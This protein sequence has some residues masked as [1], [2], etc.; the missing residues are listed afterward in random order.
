MSS[1]AF[2]PS[3]EDS[4]TGMPLF[5][6]SLKTLR[7][8]NGLKIILY[9]LRAKGSFFRR[10]AAVP[11]NPGRTSQRTRR[12][13]SLTAQSAKAETAHSEAHASLDRGEHGKNVD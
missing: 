6:G 11:L 9:G 7:L 12:L 8:K 4:V 1:P 3:V 10:R 13:R 2:A 5:I